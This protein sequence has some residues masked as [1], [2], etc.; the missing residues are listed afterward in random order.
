[1]KVY[2]GELS[3]EVDSFESYLFRLELTEN[4]LRLVD[5]L[6]EEVKRLGVYEITL[7][8]DCLVVE[9]EGEA[10]YV[11]LDFTIL[12]VQETFIRVTGVVKHDCHTFSTG[13]IDLNDLEEE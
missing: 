8:H 10:G 4:D 13:L 12:H 5:Q 1:M 6:Q 2:D 9:Q 3:F 7:F 11:R